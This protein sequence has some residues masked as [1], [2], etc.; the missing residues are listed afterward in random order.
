LPWH[1]T[2]PL[3]EVPF[4]LDFHT[5]RE[6][7][8]AGFAI[9]MLGAIESL[10]AAV[11]ADGMS[12][13]RHEPNSELIALGIANILCPFFGGIAATGALARTATNIRA[14]ARSPFS[15]TM[16]SVFV[17]ACTIA[18]APLVSYLPMAAL[19]GLL[20]VV[21]RNMS[22]ARHFVRLA[23]IAPRHDV[24]V[25]LTCFVLTVVFDM[26][27]AVT[28]GVVL[29]ALLFMRRMSVLTNVAL[30][31]ASDLKVE[32]PPGVRVYEIAG[33]LFFG[34]AKSA[35]EVLHTVGDKDHTYILEMQHVPTMDATGLVALESV[36]DRLHRSKV[37]VIFSGLTQDVS[38]MFERAGI[39]REPGKIAYAPDVETAISMAI[40]H[41]ARQ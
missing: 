20:I 35:M 34:A 37:K 4:T 39:K 27:I 22:E 2:S 3:H 25:M 1:E 28:V 19:A 15:A 29:A 40:V 14:G 16:H 26:V 36:L 6:L 17:L 30:E 7:L 23:R 13:T 8:P 9:A 38:D 21:A 5:I 24:M 18:L 31:T 12:G 33:P 41:G 32:V 10:M 11:V